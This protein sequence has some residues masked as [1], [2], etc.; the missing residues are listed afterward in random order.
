MKELKKSYQ[1]DNFWFFKYTFFIGKNSFYINF[2]IFFGQFFFSVKVFNTW[3][4]VNEDV[5]NLN[6]LQLVTETSVALLSEH[7]IANR[8]TCGHRNARK[9]I[10]MKI[11]MDAEAIAGLFGLSKRQL[12]IRKKLPK[13]PTVLMGRI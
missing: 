6:M 1:R 11:L 9:G 5:L 8:C 12:I 4:R 3:G 7:P 10:G 2:F 13:G